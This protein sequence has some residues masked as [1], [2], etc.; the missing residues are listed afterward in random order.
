[1]K[2]CGLFILSAILIIGY[3][4]IKADSGLR[5]TENA[6]RIYYNNGNFGIGTMTP[7]AGLDIQSTNETWFSVGRGGQ[8]GRVWI[9][10]RSGI[11]WIVLSDGDGPPRIKFQQLG[12]SN[13]ESSPDHQAWFGMSGM[14]EPNLSIMGAY[15]AIGDY[16]PK[17]ILHLRDASPVQIRLVQSGEEV[18]LDLTH[19]YDGNRYIGFTTE[20][21]PGSW[22]F[23]VKSADG[24]TWLA[25]GGGN[26]GIGTS[27]PSNKL[28]VKGNIQ[29]TE[30]L[31]IF[32][33]GT[34]QNTSAIDYSETDIVAIVKNNGFV[35]W[36]NVSKQNIV[37]KGIPSENTQ[38]SE[39]EVDAYVANDGYLTSVTNADLAESINFGNLN[40]TK[41][42][43]VGLGI[44]TEDTDT[45]TDTHLTEAEVDAYV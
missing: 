7:Q 8:Y 27:S 13:S 37:D 31:I 5:L 18:G 42:D 28:T 12:N 45:D 29:L 10:E 16:F 1:M 11:P 6:G 34:T 15:L 35:E 17:T 21:S 26:V 40:I 32:A 38:L 14:G 23:R 39:A 33:D 30:G 41:S 36:A 24:T 4:G 20:G 43:I 3:S 22:L 2:K 25:P 44:P 9:E 19:Y